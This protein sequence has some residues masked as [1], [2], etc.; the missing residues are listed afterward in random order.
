MP[1]LQDRLQEI[2]DAMQWSHGDLVRVSGQSSSAVSQWRGKSSKLIKSIGNMEAAQRI[3][4]ASGYCALWVAKGKGP[5]HVAR[6]TQPAYGATRVPAS[7]HQR[8]AELSDEQ[9]NAVLG[10]VEGMLA[11]YEAARKPLLAKRRAAHR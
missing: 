2:M 10:A 8:L 5:K 6:E 11:A 9:V 3:E 4:A 7:W 1:T